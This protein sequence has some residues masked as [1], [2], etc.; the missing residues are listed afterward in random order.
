M[1]HP[2]VRVLL[3]RAEA[4]RTSLLGLAAVVP[5]GSWARS[6]P[7]AEWTA[8]HHL[9][10]ALTTDAVI[11]PLITRF[12]AEELAVLARRRVEALASTVALPMTDL[13]VRAESGRDDLKRR[14]AELTAGDLETTVSL[15]ASGNAWG[16]TASISL[17]QYLDLWAS[18]DPEHEAAIRA[19]ISTPPDLSAVAHARRMN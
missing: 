3:E 10:H 16:E 7:G 13:L 5:D 18:H 6:A 15:P 2:V 12:R 14:L 8:R 1:I 4:R 17:L 19:A 11:A 9:A